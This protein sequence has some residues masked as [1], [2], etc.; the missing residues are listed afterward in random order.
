V[1]RG[2]DEAVPMRV[3]ASVVAGALHGLHAAHEAKNEAG[4]SL[5]IVHRDVSPQNLLVGADGV[6]RVLDFGVAKAI[7]RLHTTN[8]GTLRGKV[9]YMAPEQLEQEEVTR[10]SDVYAAAVVLW[11]ALTQRR[12]FLGQND[13]RTMARVLKGGAAA[14][15]T[16]APG[17]PEMD[18]IVLRGL[19]RNPADRYATAKDMALALERD[20]GVAPASEVSAWVEGVAHAKLAAKRA[21]VAAMAREAPAPPRRSRRVAWA[22]ALLA[23]LG[24]VVTAAAV[25]RRARTVA[26][27]PAPLALSVSAPAPPPVESADTAFVPTT[28]SPALTRAPTRPTRVKPVVRPSASCNPPYSI[29]EQGH[30]HYI[31]SCFPD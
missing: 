22:L 11:E 20:V 27:P 8:D 25:V 12:L 30:R 1:L 17:S 31:P 29:D 3:A 18:A 13:A 24:L 6:A 9:A 16:I 7:G 23:A 28:T 21:L 2:R 19:S 15:S 4:E 10:Q 26:P 5:H 14:P